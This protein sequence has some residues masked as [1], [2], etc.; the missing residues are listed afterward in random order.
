MQNAIAS[1]QGTQAADALESVDCPLCGPGPG[2]E[3]RQVMPPFRIVRCRQCTLTFV[4]PRLTEPAIMRLYQGAAYFGSTVAGQG[5]D[6]YMDLRPNW[7]R[8]FRRR[9]RQISPYQPRGRVLDVGCGPGFFL[10]VAAEAGY[11]VWGVDPSEFAIKLARERFGDRVQQG[12]LTDLASTAARFDVIVAFD[13]FEHIYRPLEFLD[14]IWS[15]LN[16]GGILAITTPDPT[17][18]LAR[19]SG[20]RWVSFKLPEHV[21]YW[22]EAPL[23]RA[24]RGRF[25]MLSLTRAGQYAT[26]GFLMRRLLGLGRSDSGP[27]GFV[28][29]GLNRLNVYADNGSLTLV[30]RRLDERSTRL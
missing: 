19:L 11:E 29:Q 18:T 4:S 17:S 10:E 14:N 12:T 24:L 15:L 5:Y 3:T 16:P 26:V 23:R 8:T 28:L 25:E 21:F 1:E 6:E 27:L 20:R 22:S 13:T 9:L 7:H 2:A 30:A